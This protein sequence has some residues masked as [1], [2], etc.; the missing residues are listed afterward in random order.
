[1]NYISVSNNQRID[2][3]Q[4]PEITYDL[5]FE[6]NTGFII[7]HPERHCVNYFGYKILNKVKLICCIAD[8]N[9][10]EIFIS[11]CIIEASAILNAFYFKNFMF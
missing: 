7:S 4:I 6:L 8:D 11:S 9:T 3:L 1:M 10:H 2:I 5:F